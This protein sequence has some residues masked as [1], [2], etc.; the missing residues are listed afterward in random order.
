MSAVA[1]PQGPDPDALVRQWTPGAEAG[2]AV[3]MV[4][5]SA[6]YAMKQDWEAAELWAQRLLDGDIQRERRRRRHERLRARR[7]GRD[8]RLDHFAR[9]RLRFELHIQSDPNR[10]GSCHREHPGRRSGRFGRQW[11]LRIP[12]L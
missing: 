7:R 12:R 4:A 9:H 3:A 1:T 6:A 5:L 11:E 2:D 8:R 10:S